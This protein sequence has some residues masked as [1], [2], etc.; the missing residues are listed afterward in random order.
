MSADFNIR[1]G[2]YWR[3]LGWG[4][5]VGL[6]SAIGAFVFI[7]LMNLG[8]AFILPELTDWTPFSGSWLMVGIMTLAG[9]LVGLLHHFAVF[10]ES[11]VFDALD[12]GRLD[13]KPVPAALLASLISLIGGFSL[14]PEVPTG[15]LAAGLGTWISERRK[16][17]TDIMRTN[18]IGGVSA[19]YGGLFSSPF[20]MLLVMLESA[21]VQS[22]AYYGALLISGLSA[23][24]G[25]GLFY[26]LGGDSFSSLLGLLSPP[27]YDLR[28][29]H[30]GAGML[31]GVLAVPIGLLFPI[32]TKIL[33][34]LVAP[35]NGHPILRGLLGGFLLGLLAYALPTT[36]GLGTKEMVTVSQ[37]AAEIGVVLL[38]VFALAKLLAL[39]GALAF[40]FIGGPIFP[41]LF[42]GTTIGSILM[43]LFPQLPEALALG[44]MVVAVPASI[45]PIPLALAAIGILIVGLSPS[46]ALPVVLAALVAF[47]IVRGLG[48][49]NKKQ[50]PAEQ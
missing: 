30:L 44:C 47:S 8:Q 31:M 5:L 32:L 24:I 27:V 33:S 20:V 16:M 25:F 4:L 41:L 7:A 43:L 50:A 10:E 37:Q 15:M 29:W 12:K 23:T 38:I 18:V 22:F 39:S 28:L 14:G 21:H 45:V 36:I 1:S 48:I 26:F 19:A 2:E 34:R 3:R 40:G 6:L 9:L 42:V 17:A 46:N 13:P 35:L 11:D 49:G